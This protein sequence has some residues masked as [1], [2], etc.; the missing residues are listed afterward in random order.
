MN[1]RIDLAII[2][3]L[4]ESST[5]RPTTAIPDEEHGTGLLRYASALLTGH[6]APEVPTQRQHR[7]R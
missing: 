7:K 3:G 2:A 1:A 6:L 5:D 4:T